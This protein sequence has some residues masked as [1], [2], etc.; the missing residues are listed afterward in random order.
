MLAG[1][2]CDTAPSIRQRREDWKEEIK[3][4]AVHIYQL[5]GEGVEWKNR[6]R[7]DNILHFS[8]LPSMSR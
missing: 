8:S 2:Y 7:N 3:W 4:W 5:P 1:G 6:R